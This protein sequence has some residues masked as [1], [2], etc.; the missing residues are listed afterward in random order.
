MGCS[1]FVLLKNRVCFEG[2]FTHYSQNNFNKTVDKY[3]KKKWPMFR[4]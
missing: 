1:E 4:E 3:G 2:N